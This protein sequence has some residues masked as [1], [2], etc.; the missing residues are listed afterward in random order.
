MAD[1]PKFIFVMGGPG[2][3]KGTT[4]EILSKESMPRSES[5][6]TIRFIHLGAGDLL[7]IVASGNSPNTDPAIQEKVHHLLKNGMIVPSE[8]T[9]GLLRDAVISHEKEKP[10]GTENI[11]LLD[12][13]PR[14]RDQGDWFEEA[15]GRASKVI[16]LSCSCAVLERRLMKRQ[17]STPEKPTSLSPRSDDVPALVQKRIQVHKDEC[18]PVI[19]SY[20]AENRLHTIHCDGKTIQEVVD[21]T[22]NAILETA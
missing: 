6:K 18:L 13:Y 9:F 14:R 5:G 19:E 3:G 8:I 20:G 10:E 11:F 16:H 2:C 4:C 21:A 22:R 7:R 1:N 15:F 17:A 12:G